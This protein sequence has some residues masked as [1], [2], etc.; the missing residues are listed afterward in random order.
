MAEE[1][2]PSDPA[3]PV[4]P[5]SI[6]AAR[7][8]GSPNR[9]TFSLAEQ[10]AVRI[11]DRILNNE[12]QPGSRI[13]EQDIA[14]EF[15]VSRGPVRDAFRILEKDGMVR[16]HHNRGVQVTRLSAE[17][18]IDIFEVR[19]ALFRV[20]GQKLAEARN[21]DN[22]RIMDQGVARLEALSEQPEAGD[23]YAK[24]VFFISLLSARYAGNGRLA[25][26]ITSLSLQTLRYSMLGLRT[27]E[28]RRESIK[29][30]RAAYEAIARGDVDEAKRLSTVRITKSRDEALRL[31]ALEADASGGR[32]A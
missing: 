9:Q 4:V 8:Y 24:T 23:Q 13:I 15:S 31:I 27:V 20:V 1:L 7:W 30:W 6:F 32:A 12:Y 21:P 28:R 29:L 17:E 3:S 10:I 19:A 14:N 11:G 5:G 22:L 18:V 2:F 25:D 26:I 16:M